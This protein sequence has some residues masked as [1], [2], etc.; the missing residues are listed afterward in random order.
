MQVHD[1]Y[2]IE[3]LLEY[4][5]EAMVAIKYTMENAWPGLCV[6]M[7]VDVNCGKNYAEAK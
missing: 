6:P 7:T 5:P 3:V 4:A 1:E 2:V